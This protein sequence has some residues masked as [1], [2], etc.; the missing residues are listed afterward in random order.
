MLRPATCIPGQ[1]R[2]LPPKL[3][4]LRWGGLRILLLGDYNLEI[5]LVD[6][7]CQ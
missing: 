2:R 5:F 4:W 1:F 3:K 7:S 6:T